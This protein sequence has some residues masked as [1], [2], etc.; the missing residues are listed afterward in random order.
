M[1]SKGAAH[2]PVDFLGIEPL[3][4]RGEPRD[5]HEEHRHLLALALER[6]ARREDLLGKMPRRIGLRRG[7]APRR[8]AGPER[9][10]ALVAE[11]VLRRIRRL[12]GAADDLETR[13]TA[14]AEADARGI[15]VA[16][17]RAGH[18]ARELT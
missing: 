18:R 4:K 17:A 16:A 7:E 6:A 5:V 15:L 13:A 3:R 12:A 2:E 8:N 14:A 1:R 11:A 10:A 9:R